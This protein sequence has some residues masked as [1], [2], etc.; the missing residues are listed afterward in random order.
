MANKT[1][2]IKPE[3]RD[4]LKNSD[5]SVFI[6]CIDKTIPERPGLDTFDDELLV[7]LSDSRENRRARQ[8]FEWETIRRNAAATT[9]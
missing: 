1:E 2:I 3:L 5:T 7:S 9:L 6:P 8:V 4:R